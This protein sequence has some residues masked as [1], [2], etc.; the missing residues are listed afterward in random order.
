MNFWWKQDSDFWR[1]LKSFSPTPSL[2]TLWWSRRST[3]Q[4]GRATAA[5]LWDPPTPWFGPGCTSCWRLPPGTECSDALRL[6]W[7]WKTG[8]TPLSAQFGSRPSPTFL[9]QTFFTLHSSLGCIHSFCLSV[10]Y[11]HRL[12]LYAVW[13]LSQSFPGH[14]LF[15]FTQAFSFNRILN[16]VLVEI[17]LFGDPRLTAVSIPEVSWKMWKWRYR[18]YFLVPG[19]SMY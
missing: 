7:T 3:P 19:L 10:S 4:R 8:G 6:T 1:V 16:P 14:S 18:S 11:S 12:E 17:L 2:H 9:C 15:L 5:A 13:Q